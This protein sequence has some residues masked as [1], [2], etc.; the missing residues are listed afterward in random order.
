MVSFGNT[1]VLSYVYTMVLKF[2]YNG[3]YK[4]LHGISKLMQKMP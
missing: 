3:I 1:M 2:K 4:I